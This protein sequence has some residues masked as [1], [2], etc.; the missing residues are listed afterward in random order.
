[1]RTRV[2]DRKRNETKTW[3]YLY[4]G[5]IYLNFYRIFIVISFVMLFCNP[6]LYIYFIF[7]FVSY[8]KL[9]CNYI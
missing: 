8:C 1:M 7:L 2:S 5:E 6:P 4:L 9:V 3:Y